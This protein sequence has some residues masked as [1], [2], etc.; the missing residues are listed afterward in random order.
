MESRTATA[1][2]IMMMSLESL[3]LMFPEALLPLFLRFTRVSAFKYLATNQL[4]LKGTDA[5]V[6][7]ASGVVRFFSHFPG[8]LQGT[9]H[10]EGG[11]TLTLA[12]RTLAYKNK[13]VTLIIRSGDSRSAHALTRRHLLTDTVPD[14]CLMPGHPVTDSI[15]SHDQHQAD[16]AL[17]GKKEEEFYCRRYAMQIDLR[18]IDQRLSQFSLHSVCAH[19]SGNQSADLLVVYAEAI[20]CASDSVM[21]AH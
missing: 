21:G 12:C 15:C 18:L 11:I 5:N 20:N 10:S 13:S 3:R 1:I 14:S 6:Y 2:S 9:P 19:D 4:H 7:H 16:A 8:C 17:I